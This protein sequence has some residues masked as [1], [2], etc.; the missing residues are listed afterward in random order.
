MRRVFSTLLGL[1]VTCAAGKASA[2]ECLKG[3]VD[4]AGECRKQ[5]NEQIFE[6]KESGGEVEFQLGSLLKIKSGDVKLQQMEPAVQTMRTKFMILVQDYNNCHVTWKQ[7]EDRRDWLFGF[8][9]S[10]N[11]KTISVDQL[12]KIRGDLDALSTDLFNATSIQATKKRETER[13]IGEL[14]EQLIVQRKNAKDKDQQTNEE[15][16]A[17]WN[18]IQSNEKQ[19]ADVNPALKSF[20]E[21]LTS[22]RE[23]F[24]GALREYSKRVD[25]QIDELDRKLEELDKRLNN[26]EIEFLEMREMLAAFMT[27]KLQSWHLLLGA[28]LSALWAARESWAWDLG[29]NLEFLLPAGLFAGWPLSVNINPGYAG[30]RPQRQYSALPGQLPVIYT[31][32]NSFCYLDTTVK[33]YWL[34]WDPVHLSLAFGPGIL[35]QPGYDWHFGWLGLLRGGVAIPTAT[36]RIA[37]ELTFGYYHLERKQVEFNPYGSAA[38]SVPQAWVPVVAPGLAVSGGFF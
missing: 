29:G 19:L 4:C 32:E 3:E 15:I 27:H 33:A 5:M 21:E 36:W 30:W 17:L 1:A 14:R 12:D 28:Q 23:A 24:D 35:L 38:V 11:E 26:L 8:M 7:Y 6:I 37:V 31:Q 25:G 22:Y 18:R 34:L 20:D 9:K 10:V 16:Q 13:R 2:T